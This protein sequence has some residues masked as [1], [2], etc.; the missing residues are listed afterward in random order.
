MTT[1]G[2]NFYR[3]PVGLTVRQSYDAEYATH[4]AA[5]VD[6][7]NISPTHCRDG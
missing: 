2:E 7:Q 3:I 5:R 6:E 4:H 1:V